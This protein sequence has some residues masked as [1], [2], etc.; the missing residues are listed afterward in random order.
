ML[1]SHDQYFNS[2]PY[3]QSYGNDKRSNPVDPNRWEL[4]PISGH[5]I[6]RFQD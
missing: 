1:I 6:D 2:D 3:H 4:F 5:T